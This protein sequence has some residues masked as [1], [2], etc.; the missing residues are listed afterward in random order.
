MFNYFIEWHFF[1]WLQDNMI[2]RMLNYLL[3][4]SPPNA[5]SPLTVSLDEGKK[6]HVSQKTALYTNMMCNLN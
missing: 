6:V 4:Q 3:N 5:G 1:L 2:L